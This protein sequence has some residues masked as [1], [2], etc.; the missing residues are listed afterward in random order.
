MHVKANRTMLSRQLGG[1]I[2][3]CVLEEC[4]IQHNRLTSDQMFLSL[5]EEL[6]VDA[7]PE[8]RLARTVMDKQ[9]REVCLAFD[10]SAH[11]SQIE[12]ENLHGVDRRRRPIAAELDHQVE[13]ISIMCYLPLGVG[14][15]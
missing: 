5:P 8:V 3:Q 2:A 9:R 11:R 7:E 15:K 14:T 13:P 6:V 10:G 4:A 12:R 1:S